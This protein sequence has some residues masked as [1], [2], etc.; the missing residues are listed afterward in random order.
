MKCWRVVIV[1]KA[2]RQWRSYYDW[3]CVNYGRQPADNVQADFR[4][5]ILDLIKTAGSRPLYNGEPIAAAMGY[6]RMNFVE[7]HHYFML[8][9]LVGDEA[10]VE[11]VAHFRR[12]VKRVLTE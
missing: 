3:I 7:G 12:S 5:T 4:A 2:Q 10:V 9:R 8:Y 1:G 6:R 11:Y